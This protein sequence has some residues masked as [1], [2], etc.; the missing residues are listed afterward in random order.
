MNILGS[1]IDEAAKKHGDKIALNFEN[2]KSITYRDLATNVD[3]IAAGL[4]HLG[5]RK[6]DKVAMFLPNS[7]E[8]I[9]CW[10]AA[11][12]LGAIEVPINLANRGDF[13]S[14]IINNSESKVLI[15][16]QKLLDRIQF[17]EKDL[18]KLEHIVVW[19]ER[20]SPAQPETR[21]E[22][23]VF[24][25]LINHSPT[26]PEA[27]LKHRD[28]FAMIYTSGTTGPSKG[29]LAPVG[30][31]LMAA[32]E[33]IKA[34]RCT[35]DDI[36]YT[37]LPLFHAN[38]QLLCILPALLCG[39]K[40]VIYEKLSASGFWGQIME[41][42]A[43]VFNS[44]G[45]MASFIYNQPLC[46]EETNNPVRACMA[47][48]MPANIHKDF[49]TRFQLKVIEGYG[50]TET[51]MITYNPWEAPVVGSCGKPTPNYEVR[52]F[53]EDDKELP[54][55]TLGEI[56]VRSRAPWTMCLGYYKMPEKTVETFRNFF[57]H[58]GD[59]GIMDN[60]GYLYFR[61]RVKDYIRRRGENISS[62]EVER[63]FLAHPDVAE[64]AAVA[65]RAEYAEDEVMVVVVPRKN[66][67]LTHEDLMDWC[68]PRTPYFAV[69]RYILI[70]N[71]L[72]KTPNEKI[73]KNILRESGVTENTW[74]REKAGYK[75]PR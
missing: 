11:A 56:V 21:F 49:E 33:Y 37:C 74:D 4:A 53:D 51:G 24:E 9:Y 58:T 66:K 45:A 23:H 71:E 32:E 12:K 46:E 13:L 70:R 29:V 72:P 40:T 35:T 34:M 8:I 60:D 1:L 5:V 64:C 14:Y 75:V 27:E 48:P 25:D 57:F 15:V 43:T 42:G 41:S 30:E 2:K 31:G 47:A 19:D 16:D 59:A 69:P 18:D 28:P 38:A 39:S 3:R 7:F 52:I 65:V 44:L 68:I 17:V 62:F 22:N 54:P 20:G 67:E 55:N 61:D 63:V 26:A 36:F 6:D 73:Q 10:F 50:L